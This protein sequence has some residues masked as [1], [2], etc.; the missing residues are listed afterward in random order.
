[1][2]WNDVQGFIKKLNHMEGSGIYRMPTEAEWEYAARS[3]TT[4][5]PFAFGRCLS[6]DQANYDGNYPLAECPKGQFRKKTLPV[7]S[8]S[9]NDWG[10]YD[11]HGNVW[12]W[13]Q[14]WYKSYRSAAVTNPKGPSKGSSR[15]HRG[16]SWFSGAGPCRLANRNFS[17]P[18]ARKFDLGFRLVLNP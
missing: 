12:E 2:S 16:G 5:T 10:L 18:N 15:L 8:F 6:T 7:G 13:C 4:T 3:G 1:V 17:S 9:P 11:M 14:D